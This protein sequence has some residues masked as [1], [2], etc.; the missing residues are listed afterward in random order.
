MNPF[1]NDQPTYGQ[2]MPSKTPSRFGP[3]PIVVIHVLAGIG[4]LFWISQI[5][6]AV[7]HGTHVWATVGLGVILGGA[8]IAIWRLTSL[9]ST[10]VMWVMWFVFVGDSVL[11]VFV[12]WRA[13]VLVAATVVLLLLARMPSARRWFTSPA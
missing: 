1:G 4:V 2:P 5:I 13:I 9:H 12:N 8:H 6:S 3:T 7:I 11:T 10:K